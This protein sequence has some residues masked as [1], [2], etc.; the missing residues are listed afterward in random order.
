M[1]EKLK[2][3]C[4]FCG[5]SFGHDMAYRDAAQQMGRALVRHNIE[6]VYGGGNV[7]LMG[8]IA[9][10]VLDEGGQAIGVIPD[11]LVDRELAHNG[12][13]RL[14]VVQSM[15]ERKAMMAELSDGFIAMPGGFGTFEEFCEV[16]TWSQLGLHK[17]PHGLFN[18][19]GYY[20]ALIGLFD[21]AVGEGFVSEGH[22]SLVFESD[23]A[24][25][26]LEKMQA[27]EPHVPPKWTTPL[28][29]YDET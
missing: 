19:K 9:D 7:G 3:I 29:S 18:V 26:L 22:R 24:D 20:N 16:L 15:H 8:V 28:D 21:H 2:R 14:H 12:L 10:A 13:T 1:K 11:F 23:D 27:F 25:R 17:K 6:L 5:S 4:V